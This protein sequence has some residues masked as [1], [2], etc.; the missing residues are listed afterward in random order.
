[1]EDLAEKLTA[2]LDSPEG[3][4]RV[5]GMAEALLGQNGAGAAD[6][7]SERPNNRPDGQP[8]EWQNLPDPA[9]LVRLSS[10]LRDNRE[11]DRTRLL[12]ALK[13]HLSAPRRARVDRAVQMLRLLRLAPLLQES[14]LFALSAPADEGE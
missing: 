8:D 5:R 7:P 6:A 14:G 4:E 9:T 12:L 2:L 11:D 3:M 10:L 13:P 1:M